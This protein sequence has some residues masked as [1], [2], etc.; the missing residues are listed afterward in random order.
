MSNERKAKLIKRINKWNSKKRH[1]SFS[2]YK[3]W[4]I[5]SLILLYSISLFLL[6]LLVL[7]L[8]KKGEWI[9]I[10]LF[11]ILFAVIFGISIL[12]TMMSLLYGRYGDKNP[13]RFSRAMKFASIPLEIIFF[14]E[15]AISLTAGSAFALISAV[16]FPFAGVVVL[17][18]LA[19]ASLLVSLTSFLSNAF[20]YAV[21]FLTILNDSLCVFCYLLNQR[22]V[23]N[24]K[25]K[26]KV[27][28]IWLVCLW[29]PVFDIVAMYVLDN[30]LSKD[31]LYGDKPVVDIQ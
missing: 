31:A 1:F 25:L 17:G 9:K 14:V 21:T 8:A 26:S 11:Y 7:M 24:R 16:F 3:A 2:F 23:R 19:A 28:I 15:A 20:F 4:S 5:V 27:S 30:L 29:I 18:F 6:V 12:K 13:I 22:I 10:N